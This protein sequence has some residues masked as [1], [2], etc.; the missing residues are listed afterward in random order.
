MRIR[1]AGRAFVL[2]TLLL[3]A[4]SCGSVASNHPDS[5]GGT[6]GQTAADGGI[7]GS[8]AGGSGGASASGGSSGSGGA[9]AGTGGMSGGSGGATG[10]GIVV[11]GAIVVVPRVASP[12]AIVVV[13]PRI[14]GPGPRTCGA[15]ACVVRGGIVP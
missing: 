11:R 2:W 14:G 12:G 6:G 8:G 4:A 1:S 7:G 5:G 15:S 9:G 13:N 10:N 3:G